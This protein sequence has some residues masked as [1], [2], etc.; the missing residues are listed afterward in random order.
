MERVRL[1]ADPDPRAGNSRGGAGNCRAT[2]RRRHPSR[3]GRD[4][5]QSQDERADVGRRLAGAHFVDRQFERV[6]PL[7]QALGDDAVDAQRAAAHEVEHR[8]QLVGEFGDRGVAHRRRHSL[9]R[10]TSVKARPRRFF[11]D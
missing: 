2:R 7:E 11:G 3:G 1:E 9:D 4:P 6:G 8:L 10:Q 5:A